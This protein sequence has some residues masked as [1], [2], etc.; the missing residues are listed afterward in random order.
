MTQALEIRVADLKPARPL[1]VRFTP[2]AER[3]KEIAELLGLDGLRKMNMTGELK[4]IGRSDWQFKGHLGATV[5]Q[6]CVVTL[7]PVTTRIEED[8]LRTF[9]SDWQEPEDSEVEMPEDD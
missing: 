5:I 2:D 4:A 6:P 9:V 7:A 8:I 1:P 3:M